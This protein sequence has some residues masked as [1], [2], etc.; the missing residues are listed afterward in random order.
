RHRS[1]RELSGGQKQKVAIAAA[2]ALR[3]RILV[4]DEPTSELDPRGTREI[5]SLLQHLNRDYGM[6]IL[7]IEQKISA[8]APVVP[9]LLCLHKGRIVA[10]ASP[11]QVLAQEK[12]VAELGL[13]VPPVTNLFRLLSRAGLYRG[14]L[15]L[16]VGEG[17]Q[18]L[19]RLLN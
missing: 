10:D 15:P 16:E 19:G 13:E 5:I 1:L 7:L 14:D 2:V 9:R 8:I 17:R 3:P 11:R 6:T 4:L 12:L 18:E